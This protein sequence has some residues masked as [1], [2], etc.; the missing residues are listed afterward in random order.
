VTQRCAAGTARR[1][2]WRCAW[3][4][5][6]LLATLATPAAAAYKVDIVAPR[7]VRKLLR[8]H[9]DLSRFA[10]RDDISDE[11]VEFLLTAAPRQVAELVE[12]EG[13]F[14][15]V[16]RTDVRQTGDGKRVSVMVD[17]GPR[18][19]VSSVD[20][21][22]TGAVTTELPQRE[23]ATRLAWSL[24]EGDPFTQQAWDDAKNAAL[25]VLRAEHY[26][27]A[28]IASSQASINPR[29]RRATL[30]VAFDSGPTF[31]LG[32]VEVSGLR[33]YPQSIID[34]VNPL[35]VGEPYSTARIAELQRQVQNTP[36][37][38]SV[39]IDVA[40][41]PAQPRGAPVH[42]K[43]SEYPFNS[44]RSGV[45]YSTNTGARVQGHYS[46]NN[47]FGRAWV[48]DVQGRLEQQQQYGSLQLSMPPDHSAYVNSALL[49]YTRTDVENTDIHSLRAGLQ[50]TRSRQNY[51]YS[52]ALLFY[53]DRLEQNADTPSVSRALVPSWAWTR[54]N[55]DDPIFPRRGNLVGVEAGF[56]VRGILTDQTFV[57]AYTHG[58]QY[59][60][61]GKNDLVLVHAEFGGVFTSGPSSGVP[62]SLLFR[63]GGANSVRGYSYQ[64]IGNNVAG[65]VLPTKYLIT[66]GGEYQHW[67][68]HDWGGAVFYDIGTATDNWAE[69][70]FYQGIGVGA[71]WRSPVGPIN[72]DLAY[73]LRN[74]SIR[75]YLTLGIAF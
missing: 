50:R 21:D 57:R 19:L 3:P 75:P 4:A 18:T 67:F 8:D 68:S 7:A 24:R 31:T 37:F 64:S 49:S 70:T 6:L 5:A 12:T 33:R 54:R 9:L 14:S 35:R 74:R 60:P 36:Y 40:S 38:A 17:P 63:A 26:L 1:K 39:G 66:G 46:Y 45:G 43:V 16:V 69:K 51:D 11:Q 2:R 71:R 52:Y 55:V 58:R 42:L 13:Y 62:A 65:S 27:G 44:M 25:K 20:I 72:V 22:F 10:K 29:T 15:P 59:L 48:F 32:Q 56:A 41:D 61:V 53:E 34:H 47:V 28:R 73:G 30:H 23:T